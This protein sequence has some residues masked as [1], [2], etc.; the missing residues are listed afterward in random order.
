MNIISS[1]NSLPG[2]R[3]YSNGSG[4]ETNTKPSEI[5]TYDDPANTSRSDSKKTSEPYQNLSSA[6]LR[7]LEELRKTDQ[8]IRRHEMAHIA[9]GGR[10][11]T[12]GANYAYQR[13]PDG[14]NYAVA[15][16]VHIDSSPVPGD[17]EATLRKMRQIK[18]AAL[19][20]ADP[21]AQD[22]KVAA[23]AV[24]TASQ[25]LAEL[26]LYQARQKAASDEQKAFVNPETV[27]DAYRKIT[28]LPEKDLFSFE[29]AG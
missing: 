20:P 17:P 26:M 2:F 24:T 10:Y 16:E 21:S 6:E 28:A 14:K 25:A 3:P 12:A 23:K 13:G 22:R 8:A 9:A 4:F 1:Q 5:S 27:S 7:L 19:A 11:I 18:Q 29:V 15:G